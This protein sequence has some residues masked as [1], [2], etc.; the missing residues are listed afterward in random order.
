MDETCLAT[1]LTESLN[2]AGGSPGRARVIL[3]FVLDGLRPDALNPGDTPTLF[4][5]R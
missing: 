1:P 4:R 3:L 2:V 5:L